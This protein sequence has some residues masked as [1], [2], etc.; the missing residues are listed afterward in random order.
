M[1]SK[2]L[3]MSQGSRALEGEKMFGISIALFGLL[4]FVLGYR[5]GLRKAALLLLLEEVLPAARDAEQK[6]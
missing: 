4:M 5:A 1:H 6:P 3:V 2:S